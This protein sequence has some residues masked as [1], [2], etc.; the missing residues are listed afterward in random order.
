MS[1]LDEDAIIAIG[2]GL[3]QIT[4]IQG[5]ESRAAAEGLLML[6]SHYGETPRIPAALDVVLRSLERLYGRG[7]GIGSL[8]PDLLGEHHIAAVA[9]RRLLDANLAWI[10]SEQVARIRRRRALL[11]I[12]QARHSPRSWTEQRP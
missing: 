2:R 1:E 6:D 3:G 10:E 9:D 11:T 7:D 8:E 4:L 12:L 5:V